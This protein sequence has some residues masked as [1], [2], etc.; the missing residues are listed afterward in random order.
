M[1]GAKTASYHGWLIFVPI[2][3]YEEGYFQDVVKNRVKK[4]SRHVIGVNLVLHG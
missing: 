3:L 4:I 1:L 2:T